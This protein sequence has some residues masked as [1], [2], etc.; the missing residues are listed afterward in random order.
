MSLIFIAVAYDH[1]LINAR[2]SHFKTF[3]SHWSCVAWLCWIG[4]TLLAMRNSSAMDSP[5]TSQIYCFFTSF[6]IKQAT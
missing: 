3:P 4:F 6:N 1:Y 5:R 2:D